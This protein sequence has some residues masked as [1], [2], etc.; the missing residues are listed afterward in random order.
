MIFLIWPSPYLLPQMNCLSNSSMTTKFLFDCIEKADVCIF[1]T[2]YTAI[3]QEDRDTLKKL[4]C[5]KNNAYYDVYG[6]INSWFEDTSTSADDLLCEFV[7]AIN[8]Q[9]HV[10]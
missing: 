4:N 2:N 3:S 6:N 7:Y 5:I 1:E 8:K 10:S 9:Q